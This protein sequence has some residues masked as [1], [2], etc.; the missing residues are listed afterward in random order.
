MALVLNSKQFAEY[1]QRLADQ[2]IPTV[3]RGVRAGAARAVG[4][5]V[6]RT[7][8]APPANPGGIGTGGA[9]NTGAYVRRWRSVPLPNGAELI[10][11]SPYAPVIEYGRRPG[12]FPPKGPLIAWIKRRL[13]TRPKKPRR[14]GTGASREVRDQERA[15]KQLEAG[16]RRTG[17][18]DRKY[19][20]RRRPAPAPKRR[21]GKRKLT[22]DDQA[23][24]LYFPIARA[25]ARRGLIGRRIATAPD[26][27]AWILELVRREVAEE[28]VRE[29]GRR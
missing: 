6:E 11:D 7:R 8:T 16:I 14:R 22:A 4:Y 27:Q 24:R 3:H 1:H 13:L 26:A 29:W 15:R 5:L 25:I 18:R 9:V 21:G 2:F 12:R 23:A 28:L 10:N 17:E 20:P 19:G